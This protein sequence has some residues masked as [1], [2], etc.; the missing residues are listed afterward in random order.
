MSEQNLVRK[1]E[2]RVEKDS[3]FT[4]QNKEG[5]PVERTKC[6][7]FST[8]DKTSQQWNKLALYCCILC[9]GV[10]IQSTSQ[11]YYCHVLRCFA[12]YPGKV[13]HTSGQEK[14]KI[15]RAQNIV[16]I[17][18]KCKG[19]NEI[20]WR[21][22]STWEVY[23]KVCN[24]DKEAVLESGCLSRPGPADHGFREKMPCQSP[25]AERKAWLKYVST[26]QMWQ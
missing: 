19:H 5:P 21:I 18:K 17:L 10:C 25:A 14:G 12:W 3:K 2:S 26:L 9:F 16:H 23:S 20:E 7:F 8:A 22:F 15:N 13:H 6:F 4:R 24:S 11:N 1:M